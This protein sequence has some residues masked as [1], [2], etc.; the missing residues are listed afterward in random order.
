[1]TTTVQLNVGPALLPDFMTGAMIHCIL[2]W[3]TSD[4]AS[5]FHRVSSELMAEIVRITLKCDPGAIEVCRRQYA[6]Q[7][8]DKIIGL[9]KSKSR[10]AVGHLRKRLN[11]RMAAAKI[12][13]GLAHQEIFAKPALLP[14][15]ITALS[16]DQLCTLVRSDTTIAESENI[17]KFVWRASLPVIHLAIAVQMLLAGR[18]GDRAKLGVDLQDI[19]FYREAVNLA[20]FLEPMVGAHPKFNIEA[21]TLT[22]I[23]W[24]E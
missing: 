20:Y 15:G 1:M 13:L 16:I 3:P 24:Y 17:E 2:A 21:D 23:R 18:F 5:N 22:R 14:A 4:N 19:E 11:Q 10:I 9:A 7:D 8:W 6:Q 12:G